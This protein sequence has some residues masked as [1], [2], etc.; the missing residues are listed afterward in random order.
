VN[1]L[2]GGCNPAPLERTLDGDRVIVQAAALEKGGIVL[3]A[4]PHQIEICA[5]GLEQLAFHVKVQPGETI[6]HPAQMQPLGP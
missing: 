6:T 1:V 3:L 2:K 5:P 4:R